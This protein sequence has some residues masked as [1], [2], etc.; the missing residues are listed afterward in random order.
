MWE[1]TPDSVL[2]GTVMVSGEVITPDEVE[3]HLKDTLDRSMGQ[4]TDLTI[5]Y[6]ISG[7]PSMRPD[8]GFIE[9][10]SRVTI[11]FPA[12]SI[13]DLIMGFHS[14]LHVRASDPLLLEDVERRVKNR[15]TSE[16]TM[17]RK[18]RE[19]E[20]KRKRQLKH[21]SDDDE[22]DKDNN[23]ED[24]NVETERRPSDGA[25]PLLHEEEE[26]ISS[27]PASDWDDLE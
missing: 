8:M 23:N 27:I 2:E 13:L 15:T 6:L 9:L 5:V 14:R 7:H 26:V 3:D 17:A 25:V 4:T 24:D 19:M 20:K 16:A 10:V 22:D 21:P 18:D 11:S 1:M 12:D